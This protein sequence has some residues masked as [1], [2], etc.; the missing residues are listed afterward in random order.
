MIRPLKLTDIILLPLP[1]EAVVAA[2]EDLEYTGAPDAVTQLPAGLD[3]DELL[4]EFLK[5]LR[6]IIGD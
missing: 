2:E 3:V 5:R 6:S 4:Q 1:E